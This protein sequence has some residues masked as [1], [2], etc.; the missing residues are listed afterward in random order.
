[1]RT[2]RSFLSPRKRRQQRRVLQKPRQSERLQLSYFFWFLLWRSICTHK[3][4]RGEPGRRVGV[5]A[6]EP[7]RRIGVWACRRISERSPKPPKRRFA[8]HIFDVIRENLHRRSQ[9]P[10]RVCSRL[11]FQ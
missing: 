9:R 10:Q 5:S 6:G 1:M 11:T 3:G 4:T 7:C 8:L 2:K